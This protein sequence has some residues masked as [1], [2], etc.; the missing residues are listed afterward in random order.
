MAGE[1]KPA[2]S[3]GGRRKSVGRPPKLRDA[4]ARR[5]VLTALRD[6]CSL[7]DAAALSGAAY[8]T[9]LNERERD[10]EFQRQVHQAEIEGKRKLLKRVG[11]KKPDWLLA[12][13]WPEEFANKAKYTLK[14]IDDAVQKIFA[15]L[16]QLLP[17]DK[18]ELASEAI[19]KAIIEIAIQGGELPPNT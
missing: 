7:V 3:R 17:E 2:K 19:R 1:N 5:A 13:K 12:A 18:R 11:E 6:G 14:Q 16:I 10:P 4:K 15:Q 9:L 8:N